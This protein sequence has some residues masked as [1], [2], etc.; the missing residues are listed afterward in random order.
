MMNY[1]FVITNRVKG[2]CF[3]PLYETLRERNE[4]LQSLRIG[5]MSV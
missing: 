4:K 2:D 3:V 1:N 5:Q